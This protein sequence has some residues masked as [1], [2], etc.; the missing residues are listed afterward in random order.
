MRTT[1]IILFLLSV[2]SHVL[3]QNSV[4]PDSPNACDAAF[5]A[6]VDPLN[7]MM[8]HFQDM[9]SG[10]ISLWQWSFGDGVTSTTQNPVHVYA[11][12][13]TYFVCLTVSDSDPG[14]ICSDVVCI[15]ITIHEPGT[16]VADYRY[17]SDPVNPLK[18]TFTDLSSGNINRWR[19]NFGDGGFSDDRNPVHI[20]QSAGKYN[21]CLTAYNADSVSVCSDVKCDSLEIHPAAT[22]QAEFYSTLDSLNRVPN[23]FVFK[24]TSEGN[25]NRFLWKFD[26]AA[27]Y[28][29][30]DVT[31]QFKT[32][33]KHEVC[34]RIK[35]MEQ[36]ETICTDSICHFITTATYFDMGGHVFIGT[37]PIN[38]PVSTGDT[39][40]AYL[41]RKNGAILIP[42]DTGY[43]TYNGYYTF[44]QVLHGSY[45]VRA[46]LTPGSL[47]YPLYFPAYYQQ[48]LSW[49][50]AELLA[51]TD[52]NAYVSNIHL[53]PVNESQPGPGTITGTVVQSG[54]PGNYEVIPQAQ[55]MLFDAQMNPVSF[56]FS[57]GSGQF[58]FMNL[59]YGAYYAFVEYPGKYSRLTAIW[60]DAAIPAV[61]SLRLEVYNY[62]VTGIDQHAG[63]PVAGDLFPNPS[64]D[65]VSL[66]IQMP[67]PT[68]VKFEIKSLT[69]TAVWS[70]SANC[71]AGYNLVTLPVGF[72]KAGL[73]LFLV[74]KMDGTV[75]SV[76]K[77]LRD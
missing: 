20:F 76:K 1:C 38:N 66:S 62:D 42:Y 41:Y 48:A 55:V 75:F 71:R 31:H 24:N 56:T 34:L 65:L 47:N 6:N 67:A 4:F 12:G 15:A 10:Q 49:K 61:D 21:V 33:G 58:R 74:T 70:G 52:S 68:S 51:L 14:N 29:S 23:T 27:T 13:G 32:P 63:G 8:I 45:I 77:L 22:C 25:P 60:L 72:I 54:S 16:C 30:K 5:S 35:K 36:G 40:V 73:Y 44:P 9:S 2:F 26:D 50:E 53:F 7:P 18:T 59:P 39:G 57:G 43:F 17:I 3:G 69:G 37:L 28:E 46:S 19:W 64:T 11:A